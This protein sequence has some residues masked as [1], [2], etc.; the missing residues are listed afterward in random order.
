MTAQT[1]NIPSLSGQRNF[2]KALA[3]KENIDVVWDNDLPTAY[4]GFDKNDKKLQRPTIHLKKPIAIEFDAWLWD[5]HHEISHLFKD[6]LFTYLTFRMLDPNSPL[7]LPVFDILTDHIIEKNKHGDY[8]GRD[9]IL[10]SGRADFFRANPNWVLESHPTIQAVIAKDTDIRNDWQGLLFRS[11]ITEDAEKDIERLDKLELERRL[12]SVRKRQAPRDFFQLIKDIAGD[13][14]SEEEQQQAMDDAESDSGEGE[15]EKGECSE[16]GGTGEGEGGEPCEACGGTGEAQEG[17][18][19]GQG[20]AEGQ[21]G[22]GKEGDGEPGEVPGNGEGYQDPFEGSPFNPL[23]RGEVK[24]HRDPNNTRYSKESYVPVGNN[25]YIKPNTR[26]VDRGS[27]NRINEIR[28]GSIASKQIQKF[29]KIISKDSYTYGQKNGKLHNKNIHRIYGGSDNPRVF[30]QR[31][32][33]RLKTDTAVT[34]LLDCSGSMSGTK[35]VT[36]AACCIATADTLKGLR[37]SHEI[38]GFTEG[39]HNL[40]TYL[41]KEFPEATNTEQLTER[42]AAS[43]INLNGNV[44]GESVMIAAERLAARPE[45]NKILIVLSDGFPCSGAGGDHNWYLKKTAE[46]I[47]RSSI[48]LIGIGI[49]SEAVKRFYKNHAVVNKIEDLDR[50][51]LET[52]RRNLT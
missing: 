23:D 4:S 15:G 16:C 20:K 5:A 29:L 2:F 40:I 49:K 3:G 34:L 51:L 25:E 14:R 35:Y 30:K 33:S 13:T 28:K 9:R 26:S 44:D 36:G 18:G 46:M 41:F 37:I 45:K 11:N 12:E 38:L 31:I 42:F 19:K 48:D 1:R 47:E 21:K 6:V 39:Y 52:L 32:S 17:Q 8:V 10:H 43:N 22:E 7:Q 50:V 24:D 27:I